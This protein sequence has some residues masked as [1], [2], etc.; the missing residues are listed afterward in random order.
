M[1]LIV[2]CGTSKMAIMPVLR[3]NTITILLRK[4]LLM[5]TTCLSSR[6]GVGT[7]SFS[8]SLPFDRSW[9]SQSTVRYDKLKNVGCRVTAA[10]LAS[11]CYKN[12]LAHGNRFIEGIPLLHP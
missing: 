4:R 2:G 5:Q 10:C 3:P 12:G 9:S 11:W 8:G 6:L 1:S 7:D